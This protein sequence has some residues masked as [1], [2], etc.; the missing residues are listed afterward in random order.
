MK[1]LFNEEQL[2]VLRE[3]SQDQELVDKI[4]EWLAKVDKEMFCPI[5]GTESMC[6]PDV[7]KRLCYRIWPFLIIKYLCPCHRRLPAKEAALIIL[8]EVQEA[9]DKRNQ[10]GE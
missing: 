8:E 1:E 9:C 10:E 7:C 4:K 3:I 6:L 5:S 2:M